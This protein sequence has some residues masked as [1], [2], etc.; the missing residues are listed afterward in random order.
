[1]KTTLEQL[2]LL[3]QSGELSAKQRKQLDT[4]LTANEAALAQQ[5]A[6]RDLAA[7]IPPVDDEPAPDAAARIAARLQQEKAPT[8][9]PLWKPILAAAAALTILLGV[10]AYRTSVTPEMAVVQITAEDELWADPFD[11]DFDELDILIASIELDDVD[12]LD[13]STDFIEL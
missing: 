13:D 12:E 3:E 11:A 4:E 10:R 6:L 2:L 5:S 7:A 8:V 9:R 1:M